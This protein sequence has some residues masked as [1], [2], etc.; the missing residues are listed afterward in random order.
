MK[1]RK[2]LIALVAVGFFFG[3]VD[4]GIIGTGSCALAEDDWKTEFNAI[5]GKTADPASLAKPDLQKLIARCDALKQRIETLDES[6]RKVYL[7]RL[8][9]CRDLFT[10]TMD[11]PAP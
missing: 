3:T 5:F 6:T 7:R 8:Q 11:N 1:I 10:F 9:M 4:R 2:A